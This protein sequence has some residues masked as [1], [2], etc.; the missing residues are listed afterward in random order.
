MGIL[1]TIQEIPA[2]S[3]HMEQWL[4][5]HKENDGQDYKSGTAFA[6]MH[7]LRKCERL[8]PKKAAT[9]SVA[10]VSSE[11]A[12]FSAEASHADRFDPREI[13]PIQE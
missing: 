13:G 7:E 10:A 1:S 12:E 4:S 3:F 9:Q 5:A 2:L 6:F 8:V 11:E